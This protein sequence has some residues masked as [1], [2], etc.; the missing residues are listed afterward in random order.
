M[1]E[2]NGNLIGMLASVMK[3]KDAILPVVTAFVVGKIGK[4]EEANILMDSGAQISLVRNDVSQRLR[5]GGKDVT[6]TMTTVGGKEQELK[7]KMYEV[8]IRSKENNSLFSV[9]AIGIPWNRSG[10]NRKLSRA[11]KEYALPWKW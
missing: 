4:R 3:T 7:T 2:A 10:S 6:I 5:L 11:C 1:Y 9:N 8:L